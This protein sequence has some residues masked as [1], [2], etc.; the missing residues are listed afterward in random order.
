MPLP[1]HAAYPDFEGAL[2]TPPTGGGVMIL[3]ISLWG[4][5]DRALTLRCQFYWPICGHLFSGGPEYLSG[6]LKRRMDPS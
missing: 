2:H 6:P 3:S 4:G 5:V 1:S